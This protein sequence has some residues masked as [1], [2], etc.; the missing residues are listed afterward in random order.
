MGAT[1]D[2]MEEHPTLICMRNGE[3]GFVLPLFGNELE[4]GW[5]H[6]LRAL[7]YFAGL[8]YAFYGASIVSDVF[9]E[10]IEVITSQERDMVTINPKTKVKTVHKVLIWNRTVANLSLMALGT[11][12]PE[13][14]LNIVEVVGR[15]FHAGELG[16]S[17]IVGSAAFNFLIIIA[18]CFVSIP[19]GEYR[20]IRSFATFLVTGAMSLVAYG[21]MYVAISVSSPDVIEPWEAWVTLGCFPLL[22]FVGYH[23]DIGTFGGNDEAAVDNLLSDQHGVA[24]R[25]RR[26]TTDDFDPLSTHDEMTRHIELLRKGDQSGMLTMQQLAQM[27][28]GD[29]GISRIKSR[30]YYRLHASRASYGAQRV[31]LGADASKSADMSAALA[32][33]G[34]AGGPGPSVHFVLPEPKPQ[35]GHRHNSHSVSFGKAD[36][37]EAEAHAHRHPARRGGWLC[38]AAPPPEPAP[39]LKTKEQRAS[40]RDMRF[41]LRSASSLRLLGPQPVFSDTPLPVVRLHLAFASGEPEP[42]IAE[43]WRAH[44][45]GALS[46]HGETDDLTGEAAPPSRADYALHVISLPW[47][48]I[49]AVCCP[50]TQLYGGLPCFF[51][52]LAVIALVTTIV[53]DL[54]SML[55]CIVGIPDAI[56]A[57]TLVA[58]GTSVPDTFA[59]KIAAQNEP[60]ADSSITNVTGSNSVNVFMGLG[61]PWALASLYWQLHGPDAVWKARYPDQAARLPAGTAVYVLRGGDLGFSVVLFAAVSVLGVAL[62]LYRRFGLGAELGGPGYAKWAHA[63]FFVALWVGYIVVVCARLSGHI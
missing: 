61:I 16:P 55:G 4:L 11:S 22:L 32:H 5:P 8:L 27:A 2:V 24:P 20:R 28:A 53:S 41:A 38:C 37:L 56:T 49:T 60:T 36:A 63:A 57:I 12:A 26:Q 51:S 59:S 29:L 7:L 43:L 18:I 14:M 50:P 40:A 39:A 17:T 6:W 9:M 42:T 10:S 1:R 3:G 21:W 23:A 54:A 35:G 25:E 31:E 30:A 44:I 33:G 48:V 62:L 58:I 45:V 19:N 15:G 46:A 47:K 13:I 52:T 34:E